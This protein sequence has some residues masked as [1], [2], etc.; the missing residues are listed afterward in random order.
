MKNTIIAAINYKHLGLSNYSIGDHKRVF[1]NEINQI[2]KFFNIDFKIHANSNYN[3][4]DYLVIYQKDN[5]GNINIGKWASNTLVNHEDYN[6]NL[7]CPDIG[8]VINKIASY[9]KTNKLDIFTR[10]R[11]FMNNIPLSNSDIGLRGNNNTIVNINN[12]NN[13]L[14]DENRLQKQTDTGRQFSDE[15]G[16]TIEVARVCPTITSGQVSYKEI[17]G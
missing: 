15:R 12:N 9:I 5:D 10:D 4:G 17:F 6:L 13:N 14:K 3:I 11:A 7:I 16:L 2:T 8:N 1:D